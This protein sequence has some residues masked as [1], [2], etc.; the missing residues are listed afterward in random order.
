[1]AAAE[2]ES[3]AAIGLAGRSDGHWLDLG[4]GPGRH[5]VAL[6]ARGIRVTG[7][8]ASDF[9]LERA[10]ARAEAAGVA[11]EWIE[12]D[13]YAPLPVSGV[14]VA[15]SM[16]TTLGYGTRD[17]D[18][19][20]LAEVRRALNPGGCLILELA[21]KETVAAADEPTRCVVGDDDGLLFQRHWPI[22]DWTR[23]ANHWVLVEGERATHWHFDVAIYSG[24]ELRALLLEVGFDRVELFGNLEGDPYAERPERLV[25][26]AGLD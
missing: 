18:R 6:A 15:I 24:A 9:L 23:M 10:R 11:I 21:G 8:D 13:L 7:I 1:M 16:Y 3:A 26:R 2:G 14:D 17:D 12:A 5:A 25:V 19:R 4:C 22:D 20:L